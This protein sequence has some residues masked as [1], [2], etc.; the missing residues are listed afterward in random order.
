MFAA[1]PHCLTGMEKMGNSSKFAVLLFLQRVWLAHG[2]V[3]TPLSP[4]LK[5]DW[6]SEDCWDMRRADL[7]SPPQVH[8]HGQRLLFHESWTQLERLQVPLDPFYSFYQFNQFL[9]QHPHAEP[10]QLFDAQIF[11]LFYLQEASSW[12]M[13]HAGKGGSWAKDAA[14]AGRENQ[15][16][17]AHQIHHSC[18]RALAAICQDLAQLEPE[19]F[20]DSFFREKHPE[21]STSLKRTALLSDLLMLN[22]H[23]SMLTAS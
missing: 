18:H 6:K 10:K 12:G 13:I 20:T 2:N 5:L 19:I 7:P 4:L 1:R 17:D 11:P 9:A 21:E 14:A 23:F 16:G 22:F 15:A 3:E 8:F